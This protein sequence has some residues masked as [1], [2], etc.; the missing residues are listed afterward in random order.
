MSENIQ[1]SFN[2]RAGR[3]TDWQMFKQCVHSSFVGRGLLCLAAFKTD[4]VGWRSGTSCATKL[5]LRGSGSW[6][7]GGDFIYQKPN[8][9]K[10][11]IW[12]AGDL[13]F[14]WSVRTSGA[15]ECQEYWWAEH[16]R[17]ELLHC[18]TQNNSNKDWLCADFSWNK[19]YSSPLFQ[20]TQL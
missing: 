2:G 18:L 15:R 8:W 10:G 13:E 20:L 3:M 12:G 9:D 1:V 11:K 14:T 4:T 16:Q 7:R 19:R 6:T 5:V 17:R